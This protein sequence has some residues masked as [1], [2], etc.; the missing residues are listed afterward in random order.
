MPVPLRVADISLFCKTLRQQLAEKSAAPLPSHLAMLNLIAKSA[1]YRN[2][3]SLRADADSAIAH[4]TAEPLTIPRELA[5]PKLVARALNHFDTH[6]R[7]TRFP[8]QLSV[9]NIALLALWCRIPA[10]RD[11]TEKEVNDYI[12]QFHT[13][14]DNATLRRELVNTKLLWRTKD[15]RV[16]RRLAAD[17]S[18]EG[19]LFIKTLM[20]LTHH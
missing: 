16:Y 1:G 17:E 3:Q 8:L 7:M 11:L 10:K 19:T 15:G 18:P 5:L 2:F 9:R 6:G 12:A 20:K 4:S 13:F 14:A